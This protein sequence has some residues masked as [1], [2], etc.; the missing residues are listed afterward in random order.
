MLT[1]LLLGLLV[2]DSGCKLGSFGNNNN[3][4]TNNTNTNNSNTTNNNNN[5][6]SNLNSNSNS[7]V[8]LG[9]IINIS[10]SHTASRST[11][12]LPQ[13]MVIDTLGNV[14]AA[15]EETDA[16]GFDVQVKFASM[17]AGGS[18]TA[19][20]QLSAAASSA[21]VQGGSMRMAVSRTTGE[22]H[23]IWVEGSGANARAMVAHNRS[24]SFV[25]AFPVST[26]AG[27]PAAGPGVRVDASGQAHY[28]WTR[29]ISPRRI[30]YR[31]LFFGTLDAQESDVSARGNHT[32]DDA[33]ADPDGLILLPASGEQPLG[34]TYSALVQGQQQ[35]LYSERSASSSGSFGNIVDISL[36]ESGIHPAGSAAFTPR[37]TT[38]G[39]GDLVITF[40]ETGANGVRNTRVNGRPRSGAFRSTSVNL[41]AASVGDSSHSTAP[42]DLFG[43]GLLDTGGGLHLAW[44]DAPGSG[45]NALRHRYLRTPDADPSSEAITAFANTTTFAG[46]H[47]MLS[48]LDG[49][50]AFYVGFEQEDAAGARDLFVRR[51]G[52]GSGSNFDSTTRLTTTTDDTH[53]RGFA[54]TGSGRAMV[55][56]DEG[57]VPL[58]LFAARETDGSVSGPVDVSRQSG[59]AS[60]GL[61][62][63]L[64]STGRAHAFWLSTFNGS[65]RDLF[66][67][68]IQ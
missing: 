22:V 64:S 11:N 19:P 62:L 52:A 45:E 6:N 48:G 23:V 55:L 47:T 59:T 1:G 42:E 30:V 41:T 43:V 29:L 25:T 33:V 61:T 57:V 4:N 20:V 8:T 46:A 9:T 15:W 54:V 10:T 51:R 63:R 49:S 65:M 18:W 56:G 31:G 68:A 14:Y 66:Y 34:V 67:S 27:E 21:P 16:N 40:G 38:N 26:T 2:L 28:V 39:A 53:L 13:N 35:V 24:G 37:P 32:A 58:V 3:S 36:E 17:P 44:E 60:V 5:A 7:N 12:A 50:D